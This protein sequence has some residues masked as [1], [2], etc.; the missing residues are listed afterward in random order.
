[1]I[2]SDKEPE[3][4]YDDDDDQQQQQQGHQLCTPSST[5]HQQVWSAW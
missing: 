3:H 2:G 1:M 4:D 5:Q